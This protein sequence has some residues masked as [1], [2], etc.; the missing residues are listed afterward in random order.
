M[1]KYDNYAITF[2]EVPNETSLY[3]T[4]TNCPIKC[5]NCNSKHLWNDSGTPLTWDSLNA[6]IH[7]NK[8]ISCVVFGGGDSSPKDI[9]KLAWYIKRSTG[10]K[11]CWYSGADVISKDINVANFD[12]IKVG[13]FNG[14]PLNRKGT[15]QIFWK[16]EHYSNSKF[17]LIDQTKLFQVNDRNNKS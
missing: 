14:I 16:V 11:V 4:I 7:I 12:Y 2:S 17:E 5:H 1:L 15:N 10:L 8:G 6:I 13:H 9:D 3:I